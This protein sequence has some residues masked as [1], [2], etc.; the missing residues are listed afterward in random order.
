[1]KK[2]SGFSRRPSKRRFS[3]TRSDNVFKQL[4]LS[5]E[6]VGISREDLV[7]MRR[8]QYLIYARSYVAN[9]LWH[10]NTSLNYIGLLLNRKYS[11]VR[12]ILSAHRGISRTSEYKDFLASLRSK[13]FYCVSDS[14]IDSRIEELQAMFSR[15]KQGEDIAMMGAIKNII[16]KLREL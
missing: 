5:L 11:S 3:K 9:R 16:N 7:C 1:M 12:S 2:K 14:D 6:A 15:Y 10:C 13:K 4:C 8:F